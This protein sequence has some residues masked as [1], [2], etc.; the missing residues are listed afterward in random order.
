[1]RYHVSVEGRTLE[2]EVGPDG[3]TVGGRRV[4]A[5][6]RTVRGGG[7]RSLV[8]DGA[9][10]TLSA[11][12]T[13]GGVWELHLRGRRIPVEVVDERTRAVREMTRAA[14]AAA[15]PRPV[16]APMPGMVVKV[17]V[18]EGDVVISGQGLV[19]VEAMKME[20][21]LRAEAP[22]RVERVLV[23][24]GQAVEKD[25]VLIDMGPAGPEDGG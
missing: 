5:D 15:G 25:Q 6:L 16:R 13:G 14:A 1:M 20:N 12:A 7:L 9:S 18:A 2:V 17:E 10:H 4:D 11:R 22:G 23:E 21:E 3:V 24:E 19:I 8:L